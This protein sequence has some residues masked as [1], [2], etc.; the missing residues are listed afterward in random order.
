M[1]YYLNFMYVCTMFVL[2]VLEAPNTR[3]IPCVCVNTL[4]NK[5]LSDSASLTG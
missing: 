5:A 1:F 2:S 3:H 4:D